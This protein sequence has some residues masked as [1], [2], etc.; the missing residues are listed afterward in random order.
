MTASSAP[1][2]GSS[3]AARDVRF[4]CCLQAASRECRRCRDTAA[5]GGEKHA[6]SPR[7]ST[8]ASQLATMGRSPPRARSCRL[9]TCAGSRAGSARRGP[10][11]R[12]SA[13]SLP[14]ACLTLEERAV[15]FEHA[16]FTLDG[17]AATGALDDEARC[18]AAVDRRHAGVRFVRYR[19]LC[20]PVAPLRA[21][22]GLGLV[23][24][25]PHPRPRLPSF[26]LDMDADIRIS[27]ANVTSGSDRLGRCAASLN[28]KDGKLYGEIAELELEQG[29]RGEGQFTI[30]TLGCRTALHAARRPQRYRSGDHRRAAPRPRRH[31]RRWRR[32]DRRH[33]DGRQRNRVHTIDGRHSLGGDGRRRAPGPGRRGASCSGC[34][35]HP[36]EGWGSVGAGSTA[37]KAGLPRASRHSTAF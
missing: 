14:R 4:R 30:D 16:Q 31:R 26:L 18:R 34:R 37:R 24:Q 9:S 25:H 5:C 19:P 3:S 22:V 7:H 36:V 2:G 13:P 33:S 11:D 35:C 10:Q 1:R 15:A 27:A 23:V 8:A 17:N 32:E 12:G 6:P 28:V 20:H 21:R 29:G